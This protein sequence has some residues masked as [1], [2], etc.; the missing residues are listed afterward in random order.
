MRGRVMSV[1]TLHF[2]KDGRWVARF[3]GYLIKQ[4][5]VPVIMTGNGV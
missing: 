5:S 4:T 1:T 3:A 2:V